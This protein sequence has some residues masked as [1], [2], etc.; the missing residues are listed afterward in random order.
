MDLK[1]MV[2]QAQ[3]LQKKMEEAQK[4]LAES[5]FEGS[6]G[7]RMVVAVISG[8]G[9]LKK[10]AIDPEVI[11][12]NEKQILE[13]LIVA[14]VNNAKNESDKKSASSMQSITSGIPLPPGL[15]F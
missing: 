14:A 7:G 1:A 10:V 6:S 5:E 8:A 11:N 2:R 12:Q 3:E 15:K 4:E 9:V 13:D